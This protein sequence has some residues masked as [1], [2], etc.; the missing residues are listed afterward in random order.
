MFS[1][2]LVLPSNNSKQAQRASS[3]K[4]NKLLGEVNFVWFWRQIMPQLCIKRGIDD[5]CK[6]ALVNHHK[7]K[8]PAVV[9]SAY[10]MTNLKN[11]HKWE[12][13]Q[14]LMNDDGSYRVFTP[15][16]YVSPVND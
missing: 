16:D 13:Q 9:P 12:S 7:Q 4:P 1:D 10:I 15:A 11:K 2:I 14:I 6:A 3:A 5:L 8:K